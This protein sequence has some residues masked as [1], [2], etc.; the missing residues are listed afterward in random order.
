M[1]APVRSD[2]VSLTLVLPWRAQVW[3]GNSR[4]LPWEEKC[5]NMD[6]EQ[7]TAGGDLIEE[8]DPLSAQ[9]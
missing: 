9:L 3:A 4:E 2:V 5:R 7:P 1:D 6:Q 8:P